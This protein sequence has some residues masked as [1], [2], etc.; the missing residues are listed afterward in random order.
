MPYTKKQCAYFYANKGKK[1]VPGDFEK[2]CKKGKYK[3]V[4]EAM[5]RVKVKA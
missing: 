3:K 5:M 2:Y 4:T 1:S